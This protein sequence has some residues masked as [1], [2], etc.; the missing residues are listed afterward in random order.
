MTTQLEIEGMTCASCVRRVEKALG[1]VPGVENAEVNFATEQAAVDHAEPLA[2]EA[3]IG[4]VEKAG[5]HAR[6]HES[7]H[8]GHQHEPPR[9]N[10]LI[11][12]GVLTAATVAVSMLWMDRPAWANWLLF[13]M[14]TPV[15]LWFGRQFFLSAARSALK[16]TSTMDT[17]IALGAGTAWCYSTFALITNPNGEQIYFE[18]A[19]GIVTLLLF[20]RAVE[21]KTKATMSDAIRSLMRL[22]PDTA[23]LVDPLGQAPDAEVPLGTIRVGNLVRVKPG[24]RIPVDGEVIE[25]E[26]YVDE[27]MLTGEPVPLQKGIGS[28]VT[29]GTLNQAGS[30]LVKAT[31]V[32]R[33]SVLAQ[34]VRAVERAQGSKAPIQS[35]AD[36]ISSVFV[37]VVILLALGTFVYWKVALGHSFAE[38]LIPAV[39]VLVIA[40]PCALGLATPTAIM[41]GTGRG[42]E[43]GILIKDA[44]SLQRAS[45][46]R[47][48]LFDKT[49][50]LTEGKPSLSKIQTQDG[51]DDRALSLAASA[52]ARSEH[53][54]ARALVL[55]AEQ[56]G[57]AVAKPE[58]FRAAVGNGVAAV[59]GNQT[60]RVGTLPWLYQEGVKASD[61]IAA[62]VEGVEREGMTAIVL[63]TGDEAQAVFGIT[64]KVSES[65]RG[66]VAA[67]SD[68]GLRTA[69]VT[70]DNGEVAQ[71]VANAVGIGEVNAKVLP[72]EKA[73]I[74]KRYQAD[75]SVAMVGDGINDAPALAQADLGIAMGAGTGIAI[76]TAGVTL[77]G[78]NLQ[79]VVTTLRLAKATVKTIRMNL[80]WAFGYNVVMIP[81]AM[82][83]ELGP[84]FAA[85]AMALSS[86]SVLAN[87]YRLRRFR[88]G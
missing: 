62:A 43:L 31:R 48:V 4:A 75:G 28:G 73:V 19:A 58:S 36:R 14:A 40:C 49:G 3:L 10:E 8:E 78:S 84:M 69:M 37:P 81:L 71:R 34:I 11:A 33:D 16:G 61:V 1:K 23:W 5:Y 20:G 51:N 67:L 6:L 24:G 2:P 42:A 72:T 66:A 83:G 17:L 26:S 59:V 55:A 41:A 39:S 29:G 15:V 56:R 86:L 7:G 77:L 27:S 53:P 64:D 54:L 21:A 80:F 74:V 13:A 32:G 18:S 76:E 60:V 45:N 79:G 65:A 25:G 88:S 35:L 82:T 22:T 12:A 50:T 70:G 85:A 87:S 9:Q 46:V 44:D 57:L 63:A 68:L 38:A 30:L 52:E 47:T